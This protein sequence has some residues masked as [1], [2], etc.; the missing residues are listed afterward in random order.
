MLRENCTVRLCFSRGS[1]EDP[2]QHAVYS[3]LR[4]VKILSRGS[5]RHVLIAVE[6]ARCKQDHDVE[7]ENTD[8]DR[9]RS[10]G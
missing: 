2:S 9:L 5:E 3:T 7:T 6:I 1:L 10:C 4:A 8:S